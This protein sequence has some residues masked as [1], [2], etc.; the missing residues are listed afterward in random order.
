MLNFF[1]KK[2]NIPKEL[3]KKDIEKGMILIF[4]NI[5]EYRN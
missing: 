1:K 2:K 5:L 4:Y 3:N